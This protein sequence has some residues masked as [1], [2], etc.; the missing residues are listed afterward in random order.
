[1][2]GIKW[3]G[4]YFEFYQWMQSDYSPNPEIYFLVEEN[5]FEEYG[6]Y[7]VWNLLSHECSHCKA[8][9]YAPGP[10]KDL[11]RVRLQ[12]YDAITERDSLSVLLAQIYE[13]NV[14]EG[15]ILKQVPL[16]VYTTLNARVDILESKIKKFEGRTK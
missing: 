6:Y 8:P 5:I 4:V 11:I 15:L 9:D 14:F 1:M 7:G 13:E 2:S 12:Q 3:K 16:P 10:P